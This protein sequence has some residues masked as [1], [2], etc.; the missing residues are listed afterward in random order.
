MGFGR[1]DFYRDGMAVIR[2]W[3][4][5]AGTPIFAEKSA[6]MEPVDGPKTAPGGCVL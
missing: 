5:G 6:F 2:L 4:T 1:Q 3:E